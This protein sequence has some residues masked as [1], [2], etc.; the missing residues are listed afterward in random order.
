MANRD[1]RSR[2]STT[3]PF[4]LI[5][6]V[7]QHVEQCQAQAVLVLPFWPSQSWWVHVQS[8]SVGLSSFPSV[9]VFETVKDGRWQPVLKTSF[10]AIMVAV[11]GARAR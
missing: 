2:Q 8:L 11:D 7:V 5:L 4:G 3:P 1:F 6:R 9:P 10:A